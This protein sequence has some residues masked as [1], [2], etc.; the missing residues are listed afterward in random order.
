MV[1]FAGTICSGSWHEINFTWYS[2]CSNIR[3]AST[4]ASKW[5]MQNPGTK[6]L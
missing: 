6:F 5:C 2:S 1:C 3:S 4:R